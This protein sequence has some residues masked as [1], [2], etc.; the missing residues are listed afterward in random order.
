MLLHLKWLY[1]PMGE[2]SVLLYRE[3]FVFFEFSTAFSTPLCPRKLSI[4]TVYLLQ[5]PDSQ[6]LPTPWLY[7]DFLY[8]VLFFPLLTNLS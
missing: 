2:L 8:H 1:E 6:P 5:H 7:F 4:V 3:L